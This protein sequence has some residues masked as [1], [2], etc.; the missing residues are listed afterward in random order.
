MPT[1]PDVGC[2]LVFFMLKDLLHL[3]IYYY[4]EVQ[5]HFSLQ[6]LPIL[7]ISGGS[8]RNHLVTIYQKVLN[9]FSTLRRL[10]IKLIINRAKLRIYSLSCY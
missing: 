8:L 3:S 5:A 2:D 1:W 9:I 10:E 7:R 4:I 6:R